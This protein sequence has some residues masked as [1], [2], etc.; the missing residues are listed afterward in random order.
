MP[1]VCCVQMAKGLVC[2]GPTCSGSDWLLHETGGVECGFVLQTYVS[3]R[4]AFAE[5]LDR[6]VTLL[7]SMHVTTL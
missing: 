2:Y 1:H 3:S 5:Y 4:N 6:F 7:Y